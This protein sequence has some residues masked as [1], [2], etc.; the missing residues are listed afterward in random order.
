MGYK[1]CLEM[2]GAKIVD[3]EQFGSYQGDWIA[4]VEYKGRKGFIKDY[5]GSCS[6]CD[7][8]E[9]E[10]GYSY[11]ECGDDNYYSP[12]YSGYKE[13]CNICQTEK[14]K[15]INFGKR[16]LENILS[17]EEI[18]ENV[19]K[20]IDWDLEAQEMIDFVKRNR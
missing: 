6:G 2:A 17:Y 16:Y 10:F 11:H 15:A 8:Y 1:E 14:Q 4:V 18:L 5:Y 9:S 20:D 7:A 19:S 3:Y 12:H 13:N